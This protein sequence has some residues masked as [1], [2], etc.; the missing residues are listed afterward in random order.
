M[1]LQRHEAE[2][3]HDPEGLG[4]VHPA[5]EEGPGPPED[6]GGQAAPARDEQQEDAPQDAGEFYLEPPSCTC[7]SLSQRFHSPCQTV[8][9]LSGHLLDIT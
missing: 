9:I 4:G 1:V 6:D 8:R 7:S 2:Q 5:A 3:G